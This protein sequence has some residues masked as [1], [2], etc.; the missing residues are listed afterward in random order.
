MTKTVELLE[1]VRKKLDGVT[2]YKMAQAL[3]IPRPRIHEYMKETAQADA[4]AATRIALLLGRDPL[5][6]IA[7][8][9]SEAASTEA[10]RGFWRSF[11]SGLMRT[12]LGSV[13][14]L[15]G[16]TLMPGQTGTTQAATDSHN[17]Y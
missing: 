3:E 14:L 11:H 5:E 2:D 13:L 16:G 17:V 6:V 1:A 10:K 4:Y 7:E 8:I 12:T 15:T 9:E